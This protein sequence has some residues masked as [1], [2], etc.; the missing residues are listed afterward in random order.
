MGNS[1][2]DDWLDLADAITLLRRQVAEAQRRVATDGDDGVHLSL[3][4]ITLELGME[5]TGS[6]K[7]DAGLRFAVVSVGGGAE[8]TRQAT[9]KV[10]VRLD[11]RGADHAPV[12]V[13]DE[14]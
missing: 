7:A 1:S 5:L 8:R 13:S 3:G 2:G 9:H 4:E 6:R 10:T 11:A 14:E 12:N